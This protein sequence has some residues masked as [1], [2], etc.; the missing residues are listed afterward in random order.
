MSK[1]IALY[2]RLPSNWHTLHIALWAVTIA[3]VIVFTICGALVYHFVGNQYIVSP[4][5]GSLTETYK[6]I[7]F[8]FAI[9]TIIFLGALYSVSSF[10]EYSTGLYNTSTVRFST[11][12][13]L[14]SVQELTPSSWEHG[15]RLG[16]VGR[17]CKC[18]MGRCIRH[19]R[20]HSLLLRF[21]Q[22][23]ELFVR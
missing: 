9:P 11:I 8:S 20:S 23:N 4:A 13:L 22:F 10:S 12:H 3:E 16:R 18:H 14:S 21:A 1:R 5:F 19:C 15:G 2:E 6:K 7:A 17:Y